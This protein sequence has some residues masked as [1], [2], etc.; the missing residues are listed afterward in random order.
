MVAQSTDPNPLHTRMRLA[1]DMHDFGVAAYRCALRR[2]EPQLTE[3]QLGK[4]VAAWLGCNGFEL[5][6]YPGFRVREWVK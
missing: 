6:D 4:R 3:A 5:A 2:R 1:F